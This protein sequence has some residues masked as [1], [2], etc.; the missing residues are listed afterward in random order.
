[1]SGWSLKHSAKNEY[2]FVMF[3]LLNGLVMTCY[4]IL[5][6]FKIV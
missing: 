6:R 5:S 4:Q 1:M 2:E 3:Q